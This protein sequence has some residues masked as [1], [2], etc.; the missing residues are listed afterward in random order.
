MEERRQSG[1][2]SVELAAKTYSERREFGVR[3]KM[4]CVQH[5]ISIKDMARECGFSYNS[6]LEVVQG[7]IP[8]HEIKPRLIEYMEAASQSSHKQGVE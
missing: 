3:V 1:T 7:R 6:L 5:G 2:P 4:F 8:G